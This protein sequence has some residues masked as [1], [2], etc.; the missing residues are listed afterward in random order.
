MLAYSTNAYPLGFPFKGPLLWNMRSS[1]VIL[2]CL[3]NTWTRVYSS[4]VGARLPTNRRSGLPADDELDGAD[5][6]CGG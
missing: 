1:F 3:L 4:T 5:I 6:V 2:P